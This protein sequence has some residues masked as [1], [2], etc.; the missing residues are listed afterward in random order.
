[1][2]VRHRDDAELEATTARWMQAGVVL[3]FLFVLAFPI[4]RLLEPGRRAE[5]AQ[6]RAENLAAHGA[7]LYETSCAQCHGIEGGGAIGPAI[8]SEQ[9]LFDVSD[10]QIR[11][12]IKVGV[13]GSRMAAYGLDYGGALT[14]E[15][16]EAIVVYLRTL[17]ENELDVP[18]WRFPLAQEGLSGNELFN[19]ACATCHGLDLSGAEG[20]PALGARSDASE[21]T[22][23]RLIA[24]IREGKDAMPSFAGSLTD[25]QMQLIVDY[26]REVQGR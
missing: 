2:P 6:A 13:P 10:D 4:Y 7:T 16:I 12:L 9:F 22:D 1:M 21:E 17:E 14:D 3:L 18:E 26:L 25:A 19:L 23:A 11:Q 5:A 24:R 20:I 15:Q 8:G